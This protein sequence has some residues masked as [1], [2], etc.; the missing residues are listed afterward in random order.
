MGFGNMMAMRCYEEGSKV[1]VWDINQEAVQKCN[2]IKPNANGGTITAK[3]V[4]VCNKEL[5]LS[6]AQSVLKDYGKVDILV[7]NAGVVAG[8]PFMELTERDIHRTFDVNV[9]SQ[10]WTLQ[11]FLPSMI[12]RKE[13]HIVSIVSTAGHLAISHLTDYCASKAAAKSLDEGIKRE[14]MD[15]GQD[16]GIVFTGVYPSFM[17]T[18]MFEG[19]E[20]QDFL[21]STLFS[22]RKMI[23]PDVVLE[24]TMNAIKYE[25]REIVCPWSLEPILV[26]GKLLP[27]GFQDTLAV[28]T[29]SM[30]GFKGGKNRLSKL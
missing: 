27:R 24:E 3:V 7:N 30:K 14:L 8:R 6:E 19:A 4:D 12:A 21:G 5:V 15:L 17:N 18:G 29:S 22:G 13:G 26:Y 1:I 11:A 28:K 2:T 10:F 16:E 20:Y 25:K 23:E 9:I